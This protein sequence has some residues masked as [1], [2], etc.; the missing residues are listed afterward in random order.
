M[1]PALESSVLMGNGVQSYEFPVTVFPKDIQEII[2]D[3]N[4]SLNY[5]I[6]FIGSSILT[7]TSVCIGN[8]HKVQFQ[9]IWIESAVIY[10]AIVGKAGTNKSHPLET[11]FSPIRDIDY[12]SIKQYNLDLAEYTS[13]PEGNSK[14]K[15][16]RTLVSDFTIE[17]LVQIHDINKRGLGVCNDE[18]MTWISNFNRYNN[19]SEESYWLS[20]F[21]SKSYTRDT[22]KHGVFCIKQPFTSVIGTIQPSVLSELGKGNKLNNGFIDRILFT[23]PENLKIQSWSKNKL[24][25][26]VYSKWQLHVA[27]ML[28]FPFDIEKGST[29]I[30]FNKDA[31]EMLYKWQAEQT[32]NCNEI[33]NEI[34]TGIHTKMEVYAI[35]F[36][37]ILQML[38][39][40]SGEDDLKE[41]GVNA[42]KGSIKLARYYKENALRVREIISKSSA[43][44]RKGQSELL[45]NALPEKFTSSQGED[46][47]EENSISRATFYNLIQDVSIFTKEGKTYIRK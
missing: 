20:N 28:A 42:V 7:A 25:E 27:K 17:S 44:K 43:D 34:V 2:I 1:K 40:V 29:L 37:L 19:G 46:I 11:I 9:D 4:S 15:Y 31:E 22:I 8:S 3:L 24:N 47:A 10:M 14:P 36:S 35:R 39:Y 21:S 38:Y 32:K 12:E 13:H 16:K 18:L 23:Y 26:K 30:N 5:P 33:D 6:D 41:I 45:L